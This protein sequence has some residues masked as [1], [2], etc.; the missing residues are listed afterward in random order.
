MSMSEPAKTVVDV[1]SVSTALATIAAILP[2]LAA[3]ASLIWGCIR[4]YE[5]RTVQGWLAR[6]RGRRP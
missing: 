3:L 5:T 2:P 6:R 4:I 1:L